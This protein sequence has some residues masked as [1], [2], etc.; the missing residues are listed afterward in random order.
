MR[1]IFSGGSRSQGH[2]LGG[3]EGL[4][5]E[6]ETG[7]IRELLTELRRGLAIPQTDGPWVTTLRVVY[8]DL[9]EVGQTDTVRAICS[10]ICLTGCISWELSYALI[11]R[12]TVSC[13]QTE[14]AVPADELRVVLAQGGGWDG[15]RLGGREVERV[16]T[17]S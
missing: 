2:W 11:P 10:R 9:T 16:L 5:I 6:T 3:G 7:S 17:E 8:A 12:D 1:E 4:G 14:S 13:G 15:G